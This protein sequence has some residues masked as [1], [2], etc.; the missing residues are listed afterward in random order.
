MTAQFC[1]AD[2]SIVCNDLPAHSALLILNNTP[3]PRGFSAR[4]YLSYQELT[5]TLEKTLLGKF[6]RICFYLNLYE[7]KKL[8]KSLKL[9]SVLQKLLL[10]IKVCYFYP[11]G[12][13]SILKVSFLLVLTTKY[14]RSIVRYSETLSSAFQFW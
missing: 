12:K 2:H 5:L 6:D 4:F 3:T 11:E 13:Y 9:Y 10:C 1:S 7:A 14:K 8:K